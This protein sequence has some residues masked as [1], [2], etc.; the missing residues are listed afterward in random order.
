M[1]K[2]EEVAKILIS[3]PGKVKG[4]VVRTNI[5]YIKSKVGEEGVRKI[6][7]RMRELGS[8]LFFSE[9]KPFQWYND[10][11]NSL[12]VLVTQ[13]IFGWTEDDVY[14]MGRSTVKMSFIVRMILQYFVS[15][16][17]VLKEVGR[18]WDKHLDVGRIEVVDFN[19]E[20]KYAILQIKDFQTHPIN[21]IYQK[22]YFK[23]IAD[24][25]I[26]SKEVDV[27]ET[28][29]INRGDDYHEYLIKWK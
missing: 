3:R 22:G 7:S 21:C 5:E 15:M 16:E 14:E 19:K 2:L 26:K 11:E 1:E 29:C 28:K 9:I 8:T 20:E 4:E 10:G 18:Y 12:I 6:E 17:R 24:L 25:I 23:G 13:E 27:E